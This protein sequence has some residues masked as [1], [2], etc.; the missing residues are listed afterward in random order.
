MDHI[1][2][3]VVGLGSNLGDRAQNID[4]AVGLLREDH[5]MHV[6]KLSPLYET[7]PEGGADQPAFLNGA[8]LILTSLDAS[9]I[10]ARALKIE[11]ALGRVRT[12]KN[13]SRTIDLDILWIEGETVEEGDLVVPHARLTERSFALRPLVDLAVDAKHAVTGAVYADLPLA[14]IE[15]KRVRDGE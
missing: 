1:R 13:A 9:E 8:V 14:K 7:A 11:A 10:M 4:S 6:M 2:R 12:Q 5:D 15:L 3:V